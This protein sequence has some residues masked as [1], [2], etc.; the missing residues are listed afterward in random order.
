M[1]KAKTADFDAFF[2]RI[3][4][5]H[6]HVSIKY[7]G[8]INVLNSE[9]ISQRLKIIGAAKMLSAHRFRYD[10]YQ[11]LENCSI[12]LSKKYNLDYI[13]GAFD[14]ESK[15]NRAVLSTKTYS[16]LAIIRTQYFS[17]A[18]DWHPYYATGIYLNP[19]FP[20]HRR[21]FADYLRI[22]YPKPKPSPRIADPGNL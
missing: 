12:A 3:L 16:V 9:E 14:E 13:C 17:G 10:G 20:K 5:K 7:S 4:Q 15:A 8:L 1:T 19:M 18:T 6:P 22:A 21:L 11:D 2:K